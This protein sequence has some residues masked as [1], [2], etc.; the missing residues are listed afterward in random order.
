MYFRCPCTVAKLK[1][2]CNL[3]IL[4]ACTLCK[5][6]GYD[7]QNEEE[8]V[9]RVMMRDGRRTFYLCLRIDVAIQQWRPWYHIVYGRIKFEES[10]RSTR[11]TKKFMQSNTHNYGQDSMKVT[12][13]AC[14]FMK[15]MKLSFIFFPFSSFPGL[16][17]TQK[18]WLTQKIEMQQAAIW[19]QP[20]RYQ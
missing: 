6:N 1:S 19:C 14:Q 9:R 17:A 4:V 2:V 7:E 12:H 10:S 18:Y 3:G 13:S 11:K 5:F 20:Q 15:L 8:R 16:L